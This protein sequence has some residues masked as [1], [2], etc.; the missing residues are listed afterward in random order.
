MD[1]EDAPEELLQKF[2]SSSSTRGGRPT[3]GALSRQY[4]A[5]PNPRRQDGD[6][7]KLLHSNFFESPIDD[8]DLSDLK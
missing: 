6:R 3:R 1:V 7:N 8:F 4:G 5:R 2:H